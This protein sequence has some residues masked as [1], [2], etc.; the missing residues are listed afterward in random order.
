MSNGEVIPGVMKEE[1]SQDR[2]KWGALA[3]RG[4]CEL[5]CDAFFCVKS[6]VTALFASFLEDP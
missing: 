5:G 6:T 3:G 1:R 4:D 2:G